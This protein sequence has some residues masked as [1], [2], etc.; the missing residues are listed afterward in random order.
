MDAFIARVGADQVQGRLEHSSTLS[1]TTAK[2]HGGGVAKHKFCIIAG[3][4]V[5]KGLD[6]SRMSSAKWEASNAATPAPSEALENRLQR[7]LGQRQNALPVPACG[8]RQYL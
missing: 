6:M 2:G 7:Q 3:R 5:N 8:M 1:A 4:P